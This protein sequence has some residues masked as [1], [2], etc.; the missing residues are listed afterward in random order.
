MLELQSFFEI[1]DIVSRYWQV[2]EN[3]V[4]SETD[5]NQ[6]EFS[7]LTICKNIVKK[8]VTMHYL[9][10]KELIMCSITCLILS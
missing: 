7:T 10:L 8:F 1:V 4:S 5:V 6:Y 9:L 2:K 3:C